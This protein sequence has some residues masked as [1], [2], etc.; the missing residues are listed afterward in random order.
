MITQVYLEKQ[1]DAVL[2]ILGFPC[3][4]GKE[5]FECELEKL[6]DSPPHLPRYKVRSYSQGISA[7]VQPISQNGPIEDVKAFLRL[8]AVAVNSIQQQ[9]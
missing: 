6:P 4:T 2:K 9:I 8:F 5:Y 7:W 1:G 3:T